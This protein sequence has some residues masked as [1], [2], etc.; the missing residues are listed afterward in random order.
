MKKKIFLTIAI[1][2]TLL[3]I[4]GIMY[5]IDIYRIKNNEP[6]IFS[7]WG[8]T[9]VPPKQI[10]EDKSKVN[11]QQVSEETYPA[12]INTDSILTEGYFDFEIIVKKSDN[13]EKKKILNNQDLYNNNSDY[14]LYYYGLD[15]VNVKVNNKTMSLEE[16]LRSGKLTLDGIIAK[17]NSDLNYKKITGDGCYDGGSMIYYYDTYTIVKCHTSEG[18]RDIGIGI[19]EMELK[20]ITQ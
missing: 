18:N 4:V 14:N 10:Q 15:E 20:N 2:L 8:Y 11:E 3:I 1:I 17:A 16:T 7:N 19:P 6:V 12:Q 13:I 9:Y 5:A